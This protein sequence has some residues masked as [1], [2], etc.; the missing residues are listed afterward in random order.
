[1]V[2]KLLSNTD[3]EACG[4]NEPF[5]SI[6]FTSL[7]VAIVIKNALME[8]NHYVLVATDIERNRLA[9]P[10]AAAVARY[11]LDH[12]VWGIG[13]RT[14]WRTSITKQDL[15][16][17]YLAGGRENKQTFVATAKISSSL[18][19]RSLTISDKTWPNTI[20][21]ADAR[22]FPKPVLIAALRDKLDFITNP[23][24]K[25]W[26]CVLQGGIV[27]ISK[28]DFSTILRAAKLK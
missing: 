11:C 2:D 13:V 26:G 25:K 12:S 20:L 22:N 7:G 21:L 27:R 10:S 28:S 14:W 4:I 5:P 19:M 23:R 18:C 8:V 15:A 24:S 6:G 16:V 17:I 3:V 9:K 1:M